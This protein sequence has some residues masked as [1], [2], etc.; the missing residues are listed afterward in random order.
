MKKKHGFT[1][2]EIIICIV[3]VSVIGAIS[4][5]V[6]N[7]NINNKKY[8][9]L[10]KV[11]TKLVDAL[12]V[13]LSLHPE[14]EENLMLNTKAAVVTLE[15]L[16]NEGLIDDNI[17][18][19]V[20]NTKL[21]YTKNYFTL[22]EAQIT[23][24]NP[25]EGDVSCDYNQIGINVINSW[26]LSK[27]S[28]DD[29]VIYICPRKDYTKEI[30]DLKSKIDDL[31]S[32]LDDL[33]SK[34]NGSGG[35]ADNTKDKLKITTLYD[36]LTYTAKGINPNNYVYF[37]VNSNP[38]NFSYFGNTSNKGLWRIVT[39]NSNN[40][41]E[42]VYSEPVLSNN[43]KNYT[44]SSSTWC[45]SGTS[46]SK[47]ADCTFYKLNH[48]PS[49]LSDSKYYRYQNGE[50]VWLSEELLED[51]TVSGSK[52]ES[53]YNSIVN[54]D[55]IV[56]KKYYPYYKTNSGSGLVS[57]DSSRTVELKMGQINYNQI[58]SSINISESW[59][60]NYNMIVGYSDLYADND[61]YYYIYNYNGNISRSKRIIKANRCTNSQCTRDK[62][63]KNHFHLYGDNY[64]PLITLSSKV[65]LIEPTCSE[66][67]VMG[68]KNCPYKLSC[69]DC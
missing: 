16:K 1:L 53:L 3:L 27:Y 29:N 50:N 23:S 66:G 58:N 61:Y 11:N 65:E 62:D 20:T 15:K 19:P 64:Y 10:K 8:D 7:N 6:I 22:M 40:E 47:K 41:I 54:K 48:V 42:M 9:E 31:S 43:S 26:D 57:F 25:L 35:S 69:S 44:T 49:G 36:D 34:N 68:S 30:E 12:E 45:D 67:N 4:F 60:N 2:I 37:E 39:I 21:D 24:N 51:V 56:T 46:D 59:L 32:Q 13:Y 18:N 52:K 33:K 14:V 5:V 28:S 55:W 38:D 63:S 17:S